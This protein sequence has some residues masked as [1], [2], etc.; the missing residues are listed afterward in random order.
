VQPSGASQAAVTLGNTDGKI[1]GFTISSAYSQA[2]LQA[3]RNE[4][5][6]LADDVKSVSTLIHALRAALPDGG[7]RSTSPTS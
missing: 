4:C 3:L 2:E 5:E 6:E 1:G 7:S